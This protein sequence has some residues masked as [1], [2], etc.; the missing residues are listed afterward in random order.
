ME[1]IHLLAYIC[2]VHRI[3]KVMMKW[4]LD[5]VR[6]AILD[7]LINISSIFP[8]YLTLEHLNL[9]KNTL[10]IFSH[11]LA[12]HWFGAGAVK[13]RN[14]REKHHHVNRENFKFVTSILLITVSLVTTNEVY[15]DSFDYNFRDQRNFRK[16]QKLE[17]I[18][19][20]A[21]GEQQITYK[22]T[23]IKLSVDISIEETAGQKGVAWYI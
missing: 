13:P 4:L 23:P 16:W 3:L 7:D 5:Q 21:G 6:K 11:L 9:L 18:L 12:F 20:A 8:S 14:G 2:F 10:V 1:I 22:G 17:R 19:T 15:V